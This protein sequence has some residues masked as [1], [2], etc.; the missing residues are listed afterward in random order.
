MHATHTAVHDHAC[1]ALSPTGL[2][3]SCTPNSVHISF[4][5]VLG[6]VHVRLDSSNHACH[7]HRTQCTSC[8][9]G[10][11][12]AHFRSCPTGPCMRAHFLWS[13]SCPTGLMHATHTELSAHFQFMSGWQ[14]CMPRTPNSVHISFGAVH[15]RLDSSNHACH[16]HRTQCFG[17]VHV[18]LDSSNHACHALSAHFLWSSSCPAGL[19]KSCMPHTPN[20]V[21]ISQCMSIG[22]HGHACSGNHA[23]HVHTAPVHRIRL[24]MR[25]ATDQFM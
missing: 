22:L 13:S 3:Q 9:T 25:T 2:K 16:A 19:K 23:C 10:L 17:A 21:H 1:H 18:R 4:G 24:T 7:A 6:A 20:S 15:V 8:P 5:A 14:S 12:S 11:K